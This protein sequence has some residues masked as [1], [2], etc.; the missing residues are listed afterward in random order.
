MR[1]LIVLLVL[2]PA[3]AFGQP[4][5]EPAP[6]VTES[7]SAEMFNYFAWAAGVVI[8][9]LVAAIGILWRSRG[10]SGLSAEEHEWLK[11]LKDTHD[12]RDQDGILTWV[13]PR[14]WGEILKNIQEAIKQQSEIEEVRDRLEQ[15][16]TERREQVETLLREQ[17]DMM[18]IG[19]EANAKISIALENNHQV[20][21]RVERLLAHKEA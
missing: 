18:R 10:Q 8:L 6:K 14:P 3:F 21:D 17:K 9:G 2:M 20:L 15:E 12:N 7:V 19:M 1:Y 4:G 16:K 5:P 11:W 13:V